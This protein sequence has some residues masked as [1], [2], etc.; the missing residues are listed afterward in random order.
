MRKTWNRLSICL[1][2]GRIFGITFSTITSANQYIK[3]EK[4]R[5]L[6]TQARDT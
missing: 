6:I 5:T 3:L 2:L 1:K 4:M